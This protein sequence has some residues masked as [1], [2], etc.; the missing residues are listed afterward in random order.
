MAQQQE[1]EVQPSKQALSDIDK[2]IRENV[3]VRMVTNKNSVYEGEPINATLKLY[4]RLNFRQ[5]A[6][7]QSA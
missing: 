4:Y 5:R 6:N 1:E 3:F 7:V 2:Q